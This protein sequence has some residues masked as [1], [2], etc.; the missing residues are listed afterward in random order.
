MYCYIC[1]GKIK[2]IK[3]KNNDSWGYYLRCIKCKLYYLFTCGDYMGGSVDG[4]RVVSLE[5][6]DK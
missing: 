4:I 5:V 1:G 6:D 3:H 2:K